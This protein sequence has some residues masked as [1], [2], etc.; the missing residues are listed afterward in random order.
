MLGTGAGT[1]VCSQSSSQAA[2]GTVMGT[3]VPVTG[4][5]VAQGPQGLGVGRTPAAG[6]GVNAGERVNV[7]V[8]FPL[9]QGRDLRIRM[10]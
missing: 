6:T 1:G 7:C 10:G 4:G 9:V 2:H 8:G 5:E 3:G